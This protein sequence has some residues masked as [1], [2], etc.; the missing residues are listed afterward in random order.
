MRKGASHTAWK[1]ILVL[2]IAVTAC[3]I[4]WTF[5][6]SL[7]ET[8]GV[9]EQQARLR[10]PDQSPAFPASD[11]A[12]IRLVS[13]DM[14]PHTDLTGIL[15]LSATFVSRSTRALGWPTLELSLHDASN[16]VLAIRRLG[17]AEYLGR[18]PRPGEHLEPGVHVPVL[19]EFV[20]PGARATGFELQ[21]H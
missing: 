10:F 7:L 5:R 9:Q 4:A 16:R 15:V 18:A 20:D 13:R 12:S 3:N 19:L 17:P 21:F 2:L 14:R 8:R 6:E 1:I 11:P